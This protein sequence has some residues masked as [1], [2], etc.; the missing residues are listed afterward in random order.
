MK[1]PPINSGRRQQ[2]E[3]G[4]KGGEKE[5]KGREALR[6][7]RKERN[8]RRERFKKRWGRHKGKEHGGNVKEEIGL[9]YRGRRR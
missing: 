9:L 6:Q 1:F 2:E 7:G 5:E 8:G 4:E 3:K